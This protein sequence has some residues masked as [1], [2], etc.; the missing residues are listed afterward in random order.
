MHSLVPPVAFFWPF[1]F[2]RE[3][4]IH[5]LLCP[6]AFHVLDFT[7]KPPLKET[8]G[9]AVWRAHILLHLFQSSWNTPLFSL[10]PTF[11]LSFQ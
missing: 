7:L 2:A 10:S 4:Y 9:Y 1:Y 6:G 3:V 11:F 8:G 5:T